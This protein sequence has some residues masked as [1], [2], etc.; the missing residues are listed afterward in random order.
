MVSSGEAEKKVSAVSEYMLSTFDCSRRSH[1]MVVHSVQVRA[2]HSH[3]LMS[4]TNESIVLSLLLCLSIV[5]LSSHSFSSFVF[6][7]NI[8]IHVCIVKLDV[9]FGE[10]R[11]E[12][13]ANTSN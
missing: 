3:E 8:A 12:G 11:R 6:S 4:N 9:T 10:H 13:V 5:L 1:I 2:R 7:F